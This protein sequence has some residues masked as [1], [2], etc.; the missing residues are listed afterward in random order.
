MLKTT[1][2]SLLAASFVLPAMAQTP[3]PPKMVAVPFD[4]LD[5]GNTKGSSHNRVVLPGSSKDELT[6]MPSLKYTNRG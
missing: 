4:K 6:S 2:A 5:F 1:T 3:A